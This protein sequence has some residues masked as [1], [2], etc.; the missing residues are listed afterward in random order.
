MKKKH[1][2]EDGSKL[3][4]PDKWIEAIN[5]KY[6]ETLKQYLKITLPLIKESIDR[7][8]VLTKFGE[9]DFEDLTMSGHARQCIYA[10]LRAC[11]MALALGGEGKVFAL[12]SDGNIKVYTGKKSEL[13]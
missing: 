10:N 4:M 11:L 6:K 7:G 8:K 3:E 2:F 1:D 5:M 9:E 12:K 13:K